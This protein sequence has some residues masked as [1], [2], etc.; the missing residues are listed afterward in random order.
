MWYEVNYIAV[1]MNKFKMNQ[2]D[3][4]SN[5]NAAFLNNFRK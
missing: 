2:L 4:V 5:G 1:S 3:G